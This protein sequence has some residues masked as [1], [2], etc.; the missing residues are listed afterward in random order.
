MLLGPPKRKLFDGAELHVFPREEI[1][2]QK[3][4]EI[5]GK[6][7]LEALSRLEGPPIEL[8]LY[9][10]RILALQPPSREHLAGALLRRK[11]PHL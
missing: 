9:S 2:T 7:V 1:A 4:R 5:G 8:P 3:K 11:R 10:P 6:I